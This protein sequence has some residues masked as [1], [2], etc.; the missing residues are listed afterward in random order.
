MTFDPA[1]FRAV[2]RRVWSSGDW[3]D[4]AETIQPVAD[5]L[6][7][8]AGVREG[9]DVLDVGTGS[10]NL[11]I[12]AA[13]R[14]AHVVG[15]DITPELFDAARARAAEAG[16]E[17]EWVEGDA[18]DLPF[19]DDSFDRVLSVF[20][21][22]FAPRHQAAADEL[23]RVCRPGGLVGVCGWTPEGLNG[24]MLKLVGSAMPPPPPEV[25]SPVLWGD[26][27]HVRALFA[28]KDVEL[29]IERDMLTWET[30]SAEEWVAYC[31]ENLGPTIM[32]KSLLEPEGKWDEMRGRLV[33]LFGEGSEDGR[34]FSSE[35]VRILARRAG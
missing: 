9:Q 17:V 23:V 16:I 21:A 6:V 24:R 12:P 31:E 34:R 1:A 19:E 29:E 28:D 7:E 20:G 25:E 26:E 10:G 4:V 14:G 18:A 3:P 15:C 2:Q 32:A 30:E 8:K 27:E 13:Q 35:Y 11:A 33:A 5:L 22:I